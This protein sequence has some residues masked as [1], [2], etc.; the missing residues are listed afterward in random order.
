MLD[1]SDCES[2]EHIAS[3]SEDVVEGGFGSNAAR[4]KVASYEMAYSFFFLNLSVV[5]TSIGKVDMTR[6]PSGAEGD[7][8]LDMDAVAVDCL[9]S[10]HKKERSAKYHNVIKTSHLFQ[11]AQQFPFRSL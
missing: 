1:S 8:G 5:L 7:G 2:W 6:L 3:C 9:E 10:S 4:S 11:P